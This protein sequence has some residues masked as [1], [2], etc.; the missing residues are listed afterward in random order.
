M[1]KLVGLELN[2][3]V[4]FD[5][6]RVSFTKSSLVFIRGLNLDSDPANPSSNGAGKTLLFSTIPNVFYFSTPL[7]IKKNAKKDILGK[8]SSIALTFRAGD[9]DKYKVVQAS[10]KYQIFKNGEDLELKKIPVAEQMIRELWPLSENLFYST[11]YV[12]TQRSFPFQQDSDSARLEHLVDMFRLNQYDLIREHFA[13]KQREVKDQEVKLSVMEQRRVVL[14]DKLRVAKKRL[15]EYNSAELKKQ[16]VARERAVKEL[17]RRQHDLN[18]TLIALRTLLDTERELD[19][20]RKSYTHKG[21]PNEVRGWLKEQRSAARLYENYMNLKDQYEDSVE[22]TRKELKQLVLPEKSAADLRS[23]KDVLNEE[24][25]TVVSKLEAANEERTRWNTIVAD[26]KDVATRLMDVGVDVKHG[27][28]VDIKEDVESQLAVYK[29]TLKLEALLENHGHDG[30]ATCPTCLSEINLAS[31]RGAVRAAKKAIPKLE[32]RARAQR[33]YREYTRLKA[34]LKSIDYDAKAYEKLKKRRAAISDEIVGIDNDLHTWAQD[35]TLRKTLASIKP[36]KK[37]ASPETKLTVK[38]IDEEI[39]LCGDILKHLEAK[40]K[41]TQA[42]PELATLRKVRAINTV[43]T[44]EMENREA[45]D[46]DL[47][48]ARKSMSGVT[49]RIEAH[50]N[51]TNEC[52]LYGSELKSLIEDIEKIK[53]QIARKRLFE[54]LLKAYGAKGL[55]T[56]AANEI[57]GLIETNLNHY[58]GLVFSEPFE[59]SVSASET[60]LSIM[61]DR[62]NNKVSDVRTLSGAESNFF[63]LLFVM[64][65]LPLLP[66]DRRTNFLILDEPTSHADDVSRA[67]FRERF[68]PAIQEVVPHCFIIS[69]HTDDYLEGSSEWLVKKHN[70]VSTVVTV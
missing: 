25:D 31:T 11:C 63:R 66:D 45:V 36:P 50:T 22:A 12:S 1:L 5:Q 18:V 59:F 51:L 10:G 24:Y 56:L 15:G 40:A 13:Q 21:Q 26:G 62:G 68:L 57:C 54:V 65:I 39:E 30:D 7:A 37:V 16:I 9:G 8:G 2:K 70:G 17:E 60:G 55:R 34:E 27:D 52:S 46:S 42:H 64:S 23:R 28:T 49:E 47:M 6:A 53:P 43:I 3:I 69:P 32:Q 38:Q 67:I 41:L 20:L 33:Y 35:A 61:V 14:G 48:Q 44:R 58:R 29:A 19:A 4:Y